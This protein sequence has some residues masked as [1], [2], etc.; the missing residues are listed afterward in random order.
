MLDFAA[1]LSEK[2]FS[3]SSCRMEVITNL[4]MQEFTRA[5]CYAF[6]SKIRISARKLRDKKDLSADARDRT[7]RNSLLSPYSRREFP[8]IPYATGVLLSP[9]SFVKCATRGF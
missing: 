1:L 6:N 8:N 2:T 9:A 5:L 4:Q 7:G 3:C